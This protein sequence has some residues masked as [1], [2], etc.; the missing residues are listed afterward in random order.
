VGKE[1]VTL[2]DVIISARQY[3]W[4]RW[5]FAQVPGGGAVQKLPPPTRKLIDF[6]LTQTA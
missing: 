1:S 3:L 6:G 5:V 2:S 4:V